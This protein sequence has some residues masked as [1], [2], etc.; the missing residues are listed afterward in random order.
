MLDKQTAALVQSRQKK[1]QEALLKIEKAIAN[2]I[3][4]KQK[5]AVC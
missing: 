4:E 3:D 1:K 2:L 5:I